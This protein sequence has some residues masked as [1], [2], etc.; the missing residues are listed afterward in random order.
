[1]GAVSFP[2]PALA[3]NH[4]GSF[5][6][7][8]TVMKRLITVCISAVLLSMLVLLLPYAE[9]VYA[10]AVTG[11]YH[12]P[13]FY[14]QGSI[15]FRT[16]AGTDSIVMTDLYNG[17]I[18]FITDLAYNPYDGFFWG[19]TS[20]GAYTGWVSLRQ[21]QILI[22]NGYQAP[23]FYVIVSAQGGSLN[24]RTG[25][26]LNYGAWYEIP[27]GQILHITN[28]SYNPYDGFFWGCTSYGAY[29]GW[30][31]LRQTLILREYDSFYNNT[32]FYETP[33]QPITFGVSG[34]YVT[35]S[36][37]QSSGITLYA[38]G[39]ELNV[40][41][42]PTYNSSLVVTV[43]HDLPMTY[44]GENGY[45]FGSDGV[46]HVWYRVYLP[47]GASG[48]VRSDLTHRYY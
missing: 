12:A 6:K 22:G 4:I 36:Y 16:G 35:G 5:D 3:E 10:D 2:D 41:S 11:Y 20:Y 37:Y 17:T 26:G 1:M 43:S 14:V 32:T 24:F 27:N 9:T 8:R 28:L 18:L 13:M 38:V 19:Y 31:S 33:G 34:D 47:N 44:Y 46:L 42:A 25:P 48:Y 45:G 7:R 29:T 39:D 23:D 30:V 21:T 40:R 15:H